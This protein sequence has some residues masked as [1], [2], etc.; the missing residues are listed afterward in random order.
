M[1]RAFSAV[2]SGRSM[3]LEGA[4]RGHRLPPPAQAVAPKSP[5]SC[6]PTQ[7]FGEQ[8]P[9]SPRRSVLPA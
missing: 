1:P 6:T 3:G 8:L 9:A 5:F 7:G 4:V 2:C